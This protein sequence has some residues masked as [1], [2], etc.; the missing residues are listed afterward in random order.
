MVESSADGVGSGG[1]ASEVLSDEYLRRATEAQAN[2]FRDPIRQGL[3]FIAIEY[4]NYRQG[5]YRRFDEDIIK[6]R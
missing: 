4:N 6:L 2:A 5:F 1:V 3:G